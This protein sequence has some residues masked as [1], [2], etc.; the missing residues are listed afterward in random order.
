MPGRTVYQ[1]RPNCNAALPAEDQPTDSQIRPQQHGHHCHA[2]G[3]PKMPLLGR[4]GYAA[5]TIA[6]PSTVEDRPADLVAQPLVVQHELAN[7]IRELFTLPTAL[8][9]ADA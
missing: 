3:R 5:T 9:S 4:P 6:A 2:T 8:K 7:R 1:F